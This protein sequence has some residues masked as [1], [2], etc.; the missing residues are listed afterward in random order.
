MSGLAVETSAW[1]VGS[2][3]PGQFAK[4]LATYISDPERIR[5]LTVREYG[6]TQAPSVERC[7]ELRRTYER[8]RTAYRERSA[9]TYDG[10]DNDNGEAFKVK[11]LVKPIKQAKPVRIVQRVLPAKPDMRL[12][13]L[14]R[15]RHRIAELRNARAV[16]AG[17]IARNIINSVADYFCLDTEVVVGENRTALPVTAR[18]VAAKL[19]SEVSDDEGNRRFSSTQIGKILGGRDHSTIVYGLHHYFD[20]ARKYPEMI[21]AYEALRAVPTDG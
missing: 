2:F 8:S 11:G 3:G 9:S 21:E 7:A 1:E 19:L 14:E 12:P 17:P 6:V 18:H 4:R 13:V 5:T 10:P 16:R 20:R 15:E